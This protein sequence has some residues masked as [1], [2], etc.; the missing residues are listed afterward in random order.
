[1]EKQPVFFMVQQ[2]LI[3][4]FTDKQ[5]TNKMKVV[6]TKKEKKY[7]LIQTPVEVHAEL[8]EYCDTHGFKISALTANI[9][10]KYL[11]ENK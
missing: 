9:I 11:K 5:K 10:R 3:T 7:G 8:K 6:K 1:M 4:H 2:I